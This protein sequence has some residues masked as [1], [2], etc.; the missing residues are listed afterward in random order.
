[1]GCVGSPTDVHWG[2]RRAVAPPGRRLTVGWGVA[3]SLSVPLPSLGRQQSGR[4]WRCA[5]HG[6]RKKGVNDVE[7][8]ENTPSST[9]DAP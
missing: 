8:E 5:V 6:G 4:H 2:K 1:M 9:T 7:A 3:L